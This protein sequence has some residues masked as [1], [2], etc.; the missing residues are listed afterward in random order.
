MPE[1][2]HKNENESETNVSLLG[3]WSDK[4][5]NTAQIFIWIINAECEMTENYSLWI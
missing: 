3:S 4:C 5:Y 2:L 1:I